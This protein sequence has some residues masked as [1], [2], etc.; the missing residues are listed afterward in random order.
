MVTNIFLTRNVV[1]YFVY[2]VFHLLHLMREIHTPV[3]AVEEQ[4]YEGE[5]HPGYQV[6][7]IY[8]TLYQKVTH[9]S[10]SFN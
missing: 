1:L 4:K 9:F 3:D 6:D 10:L 5:C 7:A 8:F 2:A